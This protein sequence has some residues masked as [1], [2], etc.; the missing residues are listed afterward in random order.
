MGKEV[1]LTS[2]MDAKLYHDLTTGRTV[3]GIIHLV[4][5]TPI[6]W[7]TSEQPS[8]ETATY[9]SQSKTTWTATEQI[10]DLRLTLCYL[11]V[12]IKEATYLLG[13]N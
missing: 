2:F 11:G 6:E 1:V 13:D 12:P 7:Y 10:M 8:V 3:T 9:G 4:N 5:H